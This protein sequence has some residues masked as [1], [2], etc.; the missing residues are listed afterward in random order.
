MGRV[1]KVTD[2]NHLMEQEIKRRYRLT[3]PLNPYAIQANAFRHAVA[4]TLKMVAKDA[5][6]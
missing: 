2:L 4:W 1:L 6:A 5:I 3:D